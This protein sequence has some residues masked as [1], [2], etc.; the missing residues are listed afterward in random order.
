MNNTNDSQTN[1]LNSSI[2][3]IKKKQVKNNESEKKGLK[4]NCRLFL[5]CYF[6]FLF[7]IEIFYLLFLKNLVILVFLFF[8]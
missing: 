7:L 1:D 8:N 6:S 3:E 4:Y 5:I 2:K